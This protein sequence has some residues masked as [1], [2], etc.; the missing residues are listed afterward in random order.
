MGYKA[1]PDKK[2]GNY[3]LQVNRDLYL[4]VDHKINSIKYNKFIQL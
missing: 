1:K 4:F 2:N 3:Y